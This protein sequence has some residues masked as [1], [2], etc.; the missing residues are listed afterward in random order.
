MRHG[1]SPT[2]LDAF[3]SEATAPPERLGA[4]VYQIRSM[5]TAQTL[6]SGIFEVGSW[7]EFVRKFA[8]ESASLTKGTKTAPGRTASVRR[9]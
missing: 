3:L 7:A 9:A 8:A 5:R 1:L 4:G 6:Y 2:V